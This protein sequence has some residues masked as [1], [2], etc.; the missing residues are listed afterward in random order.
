[1]NRSALR[2]G[3]A[4]AFCAG[5]SVFA[6]TLERPTVAETQIKIAGLKAERTRLQEELRAV[7]T[8]DAKLVDAPPGDILIGLPTTLV[9]EIASEAITGPLR[10]VL[11][12]LKNV[13]QVNRKDTIKTKTFLGMMTLGNYDLTVNVLEVT[14]RVKPQ[15]PRLT[16]GSNRIAVDLPVNVESGNVKAKL[17]FKWDGKK[18]AGI[19]CGDLTSE[20]ELQASV[21]PI[22]ARLHGRLVIEA[23]G[24]QLI[25]RPMLQ[26]IDLAF[27]VEPQQSTWDFIDDLIESQNAL[28]E[29]A[30][31]K[32]A[33]GDN[34]K[35]LVAQGFKTKI[36]SNWLKPITLLASF[37]DTVEV[38]HATAKLAVTPTGVS[39][40]KTR[41]WYGANLLVKRGPDTGRKPPV[42]P[43]R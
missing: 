32:A 35:A 15:T 31:R 21:P 7:L 6:Q 43:K 34:V 10:N 40:T 13:V 33:V 18:L 41:I 24:E 5:A 19:V 17:I 25:V 26:P 20:H 38:G 14:A 30:L 42:P 11:L 27:K 2:L 12:T 39:I 3:V 36:A 9:T 22:V 8:D 28:C 37:R 16:F 4:V 1:M 29:A 23:R